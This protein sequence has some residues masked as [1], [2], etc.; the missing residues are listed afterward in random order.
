MQTGTMQTG[1]VTT[2]VSI[3]DFA[4]ATHLSVKALRHYQE[5][6]LLAP[7]E[8][9]PDSGY[10]RYDLT[11]IPTAQVIRRLRD[12]DMPLED[13]RGVLRA[14]DL[15]ERGELISRHLRRLED[16]L[17]R[18]KSAVES[19]RDLLEHPEPNLPV[20]HRS[21]PPMRVAAISARVTTADLGPW[22]N[23]AFGELYATLSAQDVALAGD[24]GGVFANGLF[25][26][27]DGQATLYLPVDT[28][29]RAAGRVGPLELPPVELAVIAHSGPHDNIDRAYGALAAHVTRH[30]LAIE[31][32]IRE[33]YPVS[34]H[35]SGDPARWR[36]EIGWP[37]FETAPR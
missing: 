29:F 18:T 26:D 22:F 30:A 21:V 28:P 20:E 37:I 1:T 19:L 24:A 31:G 6:D 12:L 36:T 17:S 10:R 11:Q 15:A 7:A 8:V 14:T 33:F 5:E 4:R 3:G 34:R 27:E 32:P 13:I 2:T 25:S 35:H 23:G 9:D 16:E